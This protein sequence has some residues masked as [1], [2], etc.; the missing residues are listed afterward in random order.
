[1]SLRIY[2]KVFAILIALLAAA[3]FSWELRYA[4][5]FG[6]SGCV[7]L[8][9]DTAIFSVLAVMV[10]FGLALAG[11]VSFIP[12]LKGYVWR[13]ALGSLAACLMFGVGLLLA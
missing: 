5:A 3:F 7:R 1:M 4:T 6:A 2:L 11:V 9:E 12:S 13:I 8:S 10:S